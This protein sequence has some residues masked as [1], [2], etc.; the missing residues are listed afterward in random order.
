M[1]RGWILLAGLAACVCQV[2]VDFQLDRYN[3]ETLTENQLVQAFESLDLQKPTLFHLHTV[4]L[5]AVLVLGQCQPGW[6]WSTNQC[7]QCACVARVQTAE[8]SV[9]FEALNV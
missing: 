7:L 2:A 8:M 3:D 1:Q 6:Y 5:N 4:D 9:W